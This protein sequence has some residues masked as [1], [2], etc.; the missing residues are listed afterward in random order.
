[1]ILLC[2]IGLALLVVVVTG[3]AT[4]IALLVHHGS[5]PGTN[6][7]RWKPLWCAIS[8]CP[9]VHGR[10]ATQSRPQRTYWPKHVRTLPITARPVMGMMAAGRPRWDNISIPRRQTCARRIHSRF[11]M[12]SCFLSSTMGSA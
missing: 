12:G 1:M 9:A 2:K 4:V 7:P 5:A 3:A 6:P 8:L 10:R 11:L